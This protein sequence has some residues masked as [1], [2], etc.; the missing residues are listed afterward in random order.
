MR[1]RMKTRAKK[2]RTIIATTEVYT[3]GD[4]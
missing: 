2:T 3:E 4:T 1:I